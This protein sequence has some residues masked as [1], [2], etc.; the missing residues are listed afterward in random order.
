MFCIWTTSCFYFPYQRFVTRWFKNEFPMPKKFSKKV[1]N[2]SGPE[3][4]SSV[5]MRAMKNLSLA[6]SFWRVQT[7]HVQSRLAWF[8]WR[9]CIS[10]VLRA[11]DASMP[12]ICVPACWGGTFVFKYFSKVTAGVNTIAMVRFGFMVWALWNPSTH[13]NTSDTSFSSAS[14]IQNLQS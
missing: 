10:F 14:K 2:S 9:F 5:R 3:H 13:I 11:I 4:F 8:C 7:F 6:N 12:T 1:A